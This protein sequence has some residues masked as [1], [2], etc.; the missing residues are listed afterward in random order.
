MD[1]FSICGVK[2]ASMCQSGCN[3]LRDLFQII[4]KLNDESNNL[5]VFINNCGFAVKIIQNWTNVCMCAYLSVS[6]IETLLVCYALTRMEGEKYGHLANELAHHW[7]MEPFL[8]D[9][10]ERAK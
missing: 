2:L 1:R 6:E 5:R 7:L 3:H 10:E 9:L 8:R 4:P